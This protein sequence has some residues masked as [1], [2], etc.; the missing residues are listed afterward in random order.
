MDVYFF[1]PDVYERYYNCSSYSIDSVPLEARRHIV[2]GILFIILGVV[3]E[4]L[5]VPCMIAIRKHMD[6]TCYRLMFYI[7]IADMLCLTVNAIANGFLGIR[8]DVFCSMPNFI[9]IAGAFGLAMWC[10]ETVMEMTLAFNRCVE[11]S[12]ARWTRLLFHG[13][14]IYLWM[15]FPTFYGLYYFWFTQPLIFSGIFFSW[16]FNPHVGYIDDFGKTYHNDF[17]TFHNYIVITVLTGT[18]AAFGFILYIKSRKVHISST[19]INSH[20]QSSKRAQ[21]LALIFFQVILISLINAMA[22]SIYVYMQFV[23]ISEFLIVIGQL[24]WV[25][26]HGIPPIIYLV[27]NKTVRRDVYIM[28]MKPLSKIFYCCIKAPADQSTRQFNTVTVRRTP[29]VGPVPISTVHTAKISNS[30]LKH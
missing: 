29:K 4:I 30:N 16:F 2:L 5:Y 13:K 12:S 7:A 6:F 26:A 20:E 18:Y 24:T 22:A 19:S 11:L 9:Y 14:R 1:H 17:H 28:M 21:N 27:L 23:R 10:C 3:C 8:G 15:L 25:L